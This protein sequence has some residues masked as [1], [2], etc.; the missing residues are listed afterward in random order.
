MPSPW[1]TSVRVHTAGCSVCDDMHPFY[2]RGAVGARSARG[3][4]VPALE[5]GPRGPARTDQASADGSSRTGGSPVLISCFMASKSLSILSVTLPSGL[6]TTMHR[7]LSA[8]AGII[9]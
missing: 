6:N 2:R 4:R 1:G 9:A 8:T 7:K 3:A 5:H